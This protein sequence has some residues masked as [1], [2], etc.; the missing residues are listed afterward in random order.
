MN[1]PYQMGEKRKA[2]RKKDD[3]LTAL[4]EKYEDDCETKAAML[5]ANEDCESSCVSA[6]E[7]DRKI[8]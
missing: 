1:A 5:Q 7:I 8:Q 3:L 4:N 6:E 2:R